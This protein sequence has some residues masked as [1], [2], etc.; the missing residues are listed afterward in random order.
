MQKQTRNYYT[1]SLQDENT[2]KFEI[3]SDSSITDYF[4]LYYQFMK[5]KEKPI[6][7]LASW[8]DR[9]FSKNRVI[10][11]LLD[12]LVN[13]FANIRNQGGQCFSHKNQVLKTNSDEALKHEISNL[14][15]EN[16]SNLL[17]DGFED[18][19]YKCV[20]TPPITLDIIIFSKVNWEQRTEPLKSLID[21]FSKSGQR[22]FFIVIKSDQQVISRFIPI[23]ENIF[24][25]NYSFNLQSDEGPVI[26]DILSEM[27]FSSIDSL[28]KLLC[29]N[30]AVIILDSPYWR[31]LAVQ[32]KLEHGWKIIYDST[33]YDTQKMRGELEKGNIKLLFKQSDLIIGLPRQDPYIVSTQFQTL[34]FEHSDIN[35]YHE[36]DKKITSL[37][38][39]ISIILITY[40]NLEY[41]K[42][43]IESIKKN[44]Q[45]PNYEIIIVDNDSKDETIN[46]LDDLITH[47]ENITLIKNDKNVGF[48]AANN[49]GV[50][51]AK[52]EYLIFLNNDTIV[53]PG[54]VTK[55]YL[56]LIK[57]PSVGMVGPVTN[58][59]GNEA[60]IPVSYS[61]LS[62]IN[63]FSVLRAARYSGQV[64]KIRV[65]ALYCCII[66]HELYNYIEGLD[67]RYK[68]GM[69]EDDDLALK[70]EM[71]G[72]SLLC[73][74][75]IFIHHFHGTSF[76]KLSVEENQR[77][78][79]ENR[80]KFEKKWGITW[81]IH[82]NRG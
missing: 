31:K 67:E 52:G 23:N 5:F 59:I 60:K 70:I 6:I 32:A 55:L 41:T 69:F 44:T 3:K 33:T 29:I 76:K 75:D 14:L 4:E 62:D 27:A 66:S 58:A 26:S 24:V 22:I 54:W 68:I 40:N 50:N 10:Y 8:L 38:S 56:H 15:K 45:Y 82:K 20:Q 1:P 72:F 42:K 81:Q 77:I 28:K 25:V 18:L 47:H 53:T 7:R 2:D 63:T 78:F 16:A 64:F 57:N 73:A 36:L 21:Q 30:S 80:L 79:Q 34:L 51:V 37:F 71:A 61:E 46:Y 65:L 74:E 13:L 39:K 43:C 35:F 9:L 19:I 17:F 48:A 49:Q 11:Q 12:S